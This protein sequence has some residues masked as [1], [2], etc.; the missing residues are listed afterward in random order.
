M[1]I[2]SIAIVGYGKRVKKTVIPALLQLKQHIAIQTIITRKPIN[3]NELKKLGNIKNTNI[4]N[5]NK[6]TF[7]FIYLGVPSHYVL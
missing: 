7:E 3:P 5:L 1:D 4:D 2:P 6:E